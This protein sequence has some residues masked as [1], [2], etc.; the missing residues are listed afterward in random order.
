VDGAE[1]AVAQLR[2]EDELRAWLSVDQDDVR[3][4]TAFA[5]GLREPYQVGLVCVCAETVHDYDFGV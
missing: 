1:A 4:G 5:H 3:E 2:F